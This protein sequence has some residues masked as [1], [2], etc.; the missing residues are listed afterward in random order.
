MENSITHLYVSG[1]KPTEKQ[2]VSSEKKGA[3]AGVLALNKQENGMQ[4]TRERGKFTWMQDSTSLGAGTRQPVSAQMQ[5][6]AAFWQRKLIE[7]SSDISH[8][9][10]EQRCKV[11]K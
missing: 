6:E 11:I 1:Y 9:L 8:F 3:I 10:S 2:L 5:E 4:N 7:I